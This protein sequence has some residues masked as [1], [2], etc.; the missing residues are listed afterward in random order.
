MRDGS[1]RISDLLSG[2]YYNGKKTGIWY[3]FNDYENKTLWTI[4]HQYD[5]DILID[6]KCREHIKGNSFD[7]DCNDFEMKYVGSK[8]VLLQLDPSIEDELKDHVQFDHLKD[9]LYFYLFLQ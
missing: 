2:Q 3:F 6:S 9:L 8:Y 7:I 1:V 4:K 5:E